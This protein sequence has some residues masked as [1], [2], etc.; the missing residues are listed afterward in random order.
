MDTDER[1]MW[2]ALDLAR[3]GR[4]RTSPNPLVGAVVV[5]GGE[6]V[7]TGYHQAAGGPHA[8]VA[9]L[10]KAGE[11]A[12]GA[13]LYVNLEPCSHQGRTPPCVELIIAS[14]VNKVVAAM[15]DPNPKVSG[16][17]FQRLR[18]AG[19]QVKTGVLEQ[20]ARRLNEVYIKYITSGFPFVAVKT[21]LTLD[22]KI[23]TRTG[24]SRWITGEKSRHYVH[25]LRGQF[26]AIMVGIGTVLADNPLLTTRFDRGR[27]ALRIVV[28]SKARLPLEAR[29]INSGSRAP[30]IMATT[31]LADP[32]KCEQ[33][34]AQGVEIL[35]LPARERKVD[36]KALLKRLGERGIT[37]VLVEG[38]GRLNYSMLEQGVVDKVFL[39][40]APIICGGKDAPTAF[41]GDG[42]ARIEDAWR[43]GQIELKKFSQDL[44][45]IGYPEQK[46]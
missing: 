45:I 8:E 43:V 15:E 4:G 23:A 41:N 7:G 18:E 14:G 5:R 34:K 17:G 38:G 3:R 25:Q 9:A 26:D 13:C 2:A 16:Q 32:A 20:K 30:A 37:S 46:R 19:I 10:R 33:L 6:P 44:L 31:G 28:D 1:W 42:V 24:N 40:I 11:R 27:D 35:T 39:F 36:L 22:G 12:R 29:L 21:A